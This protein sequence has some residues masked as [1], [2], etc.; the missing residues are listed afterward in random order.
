MRFLKKELTKAYTVLHVR[1]EFRAQQKN[2]ALGR[3][4][5][6]EREPEPVTK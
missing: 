1:R 4:K 5:A 6:Q 3:R 2:A